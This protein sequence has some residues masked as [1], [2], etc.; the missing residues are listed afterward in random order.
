[1]KKT[2]QDYAKKSFDDVAHKYDEIPFFKT[3]ARHIVD[4]IKKHKPKGI[5]DVL[6]V[7]CGTGNVVLEC[8]ACMPST[9][10][11]A[12]DIAECMLAK[13]TQN[14][15]EQNLNNIDFHLQDIIQMDLDK[16]YDVITCAYALFFLPDAHKVLAS[17]VDLLKV[18][19]IV[20]FTSFTAKAFSPSNEILLPLLRNYGSKSAQEYDM[21]KWENLKQV[22]DIEYLCKLAEVN[23]PNIHS[24]TIRYGMSLDEWWELLNNTGYKGMLMELNPEDYDC[25]Q[26][27]YYE[28]MYKYA[29]MDGEVELV[30]D[31]WFVVVNHNENDDS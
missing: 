28:A 31:S 23:T 10:F 20:V 19:G 27:E 1:M 12:V 5:L 29:D 14:A 16:K 9:S 15:K 17:L 21:D 8:V 30:A 2:E 22:K 6:D 4:I 7:A 25:V 18:D 24:K 26:N 3:S 13:A 11:D